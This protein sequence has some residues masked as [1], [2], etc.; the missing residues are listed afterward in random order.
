ML[1]N[2]HPSFTRCYVW[3]LDHVFLTSRVRQPWKYGKL[4]RFL[5]YRVLLE[6]PTKMIADG[7]LLQ[8]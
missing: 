8:A 2:L 5:L 7:R 4:N 6:N 1:S 3:F